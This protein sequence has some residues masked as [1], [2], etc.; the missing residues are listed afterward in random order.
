MIFGRKYGE[1]A[2][3]KAMK[4]KFKL[5][6]KPCGYAISSICDTTVKVAMKILARKVM[7]KCHT[8]EVSVPVVA[9]VVYYTEGV[10][11]NWSN[12]LHKEFLANYHKA[13]ELNKT[14]HYAWLLLLIVLV[15]WEL[16]QDTQ[17]PSIVPELL[18]AMK[19]ASLW[20]TKDVQHIKDNKIFQIFMEINIYM[21]INHRPQLSPMCLP[22][23]KAMENLKQIFTMC[24]LGR[25]RTLHR[26]GMNF[27]TQHQMTPMIQ[28][29]I[30]GRKSGAL[31]QT[32]WWEGAGLP[33]RKIT[34]RPS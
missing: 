24:P 34:M 29:L 27:L 30:N 20:A 2:L 4:Q 15:A 3:T 12:Y 1:Q 10:Q 18:E 14:F 9:L 19:Y 6:K 25:R 8:N 5:V 28:Y 13:L 31:Q 32:C 22:T 33:C 17:F 11:F 23:Y 16:P 7:R 26:N 21:A